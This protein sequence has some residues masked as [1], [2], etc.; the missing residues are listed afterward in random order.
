[1]NRAPPS[2]TPSPM[3]HEEMP[4]AA[5]FQTLGKGASPR[6]E[7]VLSTNVGTTRKHSNSH[8]PNLS[9]IQDTTAVSINNE[10]SLLDQSHISAT[11]GKASPLFGGYSGRQ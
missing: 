5:K 1:M 3:L 9:S 2:Y 4:S 7:E 10:T 6:L 8:M 11:G